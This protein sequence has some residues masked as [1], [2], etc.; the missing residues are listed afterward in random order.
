MIDDRG[1]GETARLIL[2][3]KEQQSMDK[4]KFEQGLAVR[5]EVLGDEYVDKAVAAT[6]DFTRPMQELLN[7][8]CWGTIWTRPG[9]PRKTRSLVTLAFLSALRATSEIKSHVRGALRNGCTVQEIQ[10]VLLQASVYVGVP[11]GI[12][13][14]RAAKEVIDT[15]KDERP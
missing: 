2:W 14:F 6:T 10:E 11:A 15:W 3:G 9:L 1:A 7:E 5:R 13:A 4:Q 12:E 8:N